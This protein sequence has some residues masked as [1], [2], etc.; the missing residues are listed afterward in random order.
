MHEL[1]FLYTRLLNIFI[2][3]VDQFGYFLSREISLTVVIIINNFSA[4]SF[5]KTQ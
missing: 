4:G 1:A 5:T 2:E 3:I